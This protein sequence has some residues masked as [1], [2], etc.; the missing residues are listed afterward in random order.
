M[1]T[2]AVIS[3]VEQGLALSCHRDHGKPTSYDDDGNLKKV[4]QEEF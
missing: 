3:P 1:K 2:E 4:H